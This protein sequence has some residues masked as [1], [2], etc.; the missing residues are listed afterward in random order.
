MHMY[1]CCMTCHILT[2]ASV[3][4]T[5]GGY[6]RCVCALAWV[7]DSSYFYAKLTGDQHESEPIKLSDAEA[8]LSKHAYL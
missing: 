1:A 8:G 2:T 6:F 4:A 5:P 7:T 3:C